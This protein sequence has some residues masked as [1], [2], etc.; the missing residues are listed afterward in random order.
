MKYIT[1]RIKKLNKREQVL[2]FA[3]AGCVALWILYGFICEPLYNK[4]VKLGKDTELSKIKLKKGIQIFKQKES[5]DTEYDK[6]I[7]NF[8]AVGTDEEEMAVILNEIET[9]ARKSYVRITNMKPRRVVKKKNFR[10]FY[11]E[12]DTEASMRNILSFIKTLKDSKF[13]LRVERLSLNSRA[14]DPSILIGKMTV[15]RLGIDIKK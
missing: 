15:S 2:F 7:E 11:V 13:A 8:T 3:V 6:Y 12:L 14:K 10:M 5:M 4:W 9:K 1:D